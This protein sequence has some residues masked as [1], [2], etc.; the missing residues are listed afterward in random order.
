MWR[1]D[2]VNRSIPC[3]KVCAVKPYGWREQI[4]FAIPEYLT[5][6]E[7]E[8][9]MTAVCQ[10]GRHRVRD[11]TLILLMYRHGLRVA[12]AIALRWEA[13]DPRGSL[14]HVQRLK[15]G[16]SAVHPLRGPELRALRQLQHRSP[17]TPNVFV[18]ERGGSLTARAV[19]HIVLR[20]GQVSGL[21]PHGFAALRARH[22]ASPSASVPSGR[23]YG[24]GRTAAHHGWFTEGVDTADLK[25]AK[26]SLDIPVR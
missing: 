22:P 6:H 16:R 26:A 15:Q 5:L 18:S 3:V 10:V 14:V 1:N 13:V 11:A 12:E 24:R 4:G 25:D 21:A 19:R 8:Q 17:G 9:V 23:P 20:A 7:V 2:P